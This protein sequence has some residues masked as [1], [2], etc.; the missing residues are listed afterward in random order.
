MAEEKGKTGRDE[1]AQSLEDVFI[2]V[3]TMIKGELQGTNNQ[4]LLLETMNQRVAEEYDGYGDVA[5]G[6][7]LLSTPSKLR[8]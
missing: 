7:R 2:N 4:L 6:L 3:S 8:R 5:S 1:L